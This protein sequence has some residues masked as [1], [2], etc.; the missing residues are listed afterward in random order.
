MAS[1]KLRESTRAINIRILNK[2]IRTYE[3]TIA[4]AQ[5]IGLLPTALTCPKLIYKYQIQRSKAPSS[6]HSIIIH[7]DLSS[8]A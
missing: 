4:F 6:V 7:I 1:K 3:L 8:V 2:Q 5:N